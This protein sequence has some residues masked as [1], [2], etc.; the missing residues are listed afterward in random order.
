MKVSQNELT[1]V[2]RR[3]FEALSFPAGDHEDAADMV[4]W[5]EQHGLNG[6][7]A[8]KR[9]LDHMASTSFPAPSRLYD[10]P[11]LAVI[12]AAD[13]SIL[14]CGSMAADLAYARAR[15]KGL[16]MVKVRHCHNRRLMLGSLARCA[17]RGMNMLAFWRN[18][19]APLVVEQVVSIRAGEDF[20]T[21]LLYE[22]EDRDDA[23]T[24]NHSVTVIASPHFDLAPSLHP[25][26]EEVSLLRVLEPESFRAQ[27]QRVLREGMEVDEA[28]WE[29]LKT[30]S[31]E[32]LVEE[33]E[34]SRR[35]GAGEDAG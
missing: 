34:A 7:A 23:C 28:L 14:V 8:L 30:L 18:H 16:A 35:Q 20:P 22:V 10:D 12:D 5:L 11:S 29:R 9:G 24:R 31:R 17:R 4:V 2:C 3:V 26:P 1:G 15:R 21:L 32:L 27:S 33:S 25:D 19:Q 6:V 13:N